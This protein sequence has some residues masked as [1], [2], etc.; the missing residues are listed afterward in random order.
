MKKAKQTNSDD[1][2]KPGGPVLEVAVQAG[3]DRRAVVARTLLRPTVQAAAT[4]QGFSSERKSDRDDLKALVTE[5]STQTAALA[6]GDLS[7]A[8]AML[9]AQA[10]T[11]DAIFGTLARRAVTQEYLRQYET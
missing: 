5:L 4:I 11:L 8:E 7:R 10:H 1:A 6:A 2:A 9:L 3:E